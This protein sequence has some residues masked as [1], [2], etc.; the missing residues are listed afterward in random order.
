MFD[1]SVSR[2][3]RQA[4]LVDQGTLDAVL[5]IAAEFQRQTRS[6]IL[7]RYGL[8]EEVLRAIQKSGAEQSLP[9]QERRRLEDIARVA[10]HLEKL[11]AEVKLVNEVEI[12]DV[13]VADISL[14]SNVGP[15]AIDT[16]TIHVG[17]KSEAHMRLKFSNGTF[18]AVWNVR[19]TVETVEHTDARIRELVHQ[20]QRPWW[21]LNSYLT[22]IILMFFPLVVTAVTVLITSVVK[23]ATVPQATPQ[24]ALAAALTSLQPYEGFAIT[25]WWAWIVAGWFLNGWAWKQWTRLFPKA[26]F[27]MGLNAEHSLARAK[28]RVAIL[29]AIFAIFVTPYVLP[30]LAAFAAR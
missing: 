13:D 19:G 9:Y 21:I 30:A 16:L 6:A 2:F 18:S 3:H 10:T 4:V 24:G 17:P 26:D 28:T 22:A 12:E 20:V 7:V 23:Y 29:S 5:R 27:R 14:H 8:T 25:V 15:R 11:V 1:A